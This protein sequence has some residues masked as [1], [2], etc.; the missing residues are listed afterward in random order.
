LTASNG[1]SSGAR[2]GRGFPGSASETVSSR[3][4]ARLASLNSHRNEIGKRRRLDLEEEVADV[5]PLMN[6]RVRGEPAR[7]LLELP[8]ISGPISAAGVMPGDGHVDQALKEVALGCLGGAPEI[9]QHLVGLEVPAAVD[10]LEPAL[11]LVALK[12][13]L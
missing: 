13:R 5:D 2:V 10:Q 1:F 11:E 3:C 9:L 12:G 4:I 8:L 6:R 7:R